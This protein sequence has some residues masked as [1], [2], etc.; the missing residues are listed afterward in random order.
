MHGEGGSRARLNLVNASLL[1]AGSRLP[2][3]LGGK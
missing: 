2:T 1:S 3:P